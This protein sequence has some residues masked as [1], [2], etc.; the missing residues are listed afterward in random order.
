MAEF[1]LLK[2]PNTEFIL[3]NGCHASEY[4]GEA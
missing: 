3:L 2:A 4:L 1:V